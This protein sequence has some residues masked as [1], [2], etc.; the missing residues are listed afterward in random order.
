MDE[1]AHLRRAY[2]RSVFRPPAR[3]RAVLYALRAS[4]A[5]LP[6]P[7]TR[8]GKGLGMEDSDCGF[9]RTRDNL[10]HTKVALAQ[11]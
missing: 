4:I 10:L 7:A 9:L 2:L 6:V 3:K 5:T 11:E 1:L 8:F